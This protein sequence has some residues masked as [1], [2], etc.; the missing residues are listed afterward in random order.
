MNSISSED[1]KY[2]QG[3][4][5]AL[6]SVVSILAVASATIDADARAALISALD[7][8]SD[9]ISALDTRADRHTVEGFNRVVD[10]VRESLG[11]S[12]AN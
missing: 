7:S 10:D 8:I 5:T 9:S 4:I 12:S 6:T 11:K 1:I 3:Q 2:I